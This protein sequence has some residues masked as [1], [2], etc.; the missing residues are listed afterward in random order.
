MHRFRSVNTPIKGLTAD[1]LVCL[2]LL[3]LCVI[4]GLTLFQI[5][6]AEIAF[7]RSPVYQRHAPN[8]LDPLFAISQL[9]GT[10]ANGEATNNGPPA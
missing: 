2:F 6:V 4:Q 7:K 9:L 3:V 10:K 1:I 5:T 8:Q